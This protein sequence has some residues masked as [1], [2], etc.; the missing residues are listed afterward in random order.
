MW[1]VH[2]P[3]SICNYCEE[4]VNPCGRVLHFRDP[5]LG[6]PTGPLLVFKG[7]C[8]Y[9]TEEPIETRLKSLLN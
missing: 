6:T 9:P 7:A 3:F 2:H 5:V 8:G 1:W 4:P